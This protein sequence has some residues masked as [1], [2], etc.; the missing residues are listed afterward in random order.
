MKQ[1][2]ILIKPRITEKATMTAESGVYVFEVNPDATK[3]QIGD[4]VKKY[5]NVTPVKVNTAV[6]PSK[7]VSSRL[8]G[9][10]GIKKGG[11]KAYVHLKKGDK[12]EIV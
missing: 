12:I 6:I 7:K 10:F 11:K 5:Y 2:S 4:A 1:S 3:K 8:R 9:H